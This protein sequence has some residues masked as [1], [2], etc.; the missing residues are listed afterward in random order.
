MKIHPND[1]IERNKKN[2]LRLNERNG[3]SLCENGQHNWEIL[4]KKLPVPQTTVVFVETEYISNKLINRL[5]LYSFCS[6]TSCI[7]FA[8]YVQTTQSC[9]P[10]LFAK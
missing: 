7:F 6:A 4:L 5:I 3:T 9:W 2:N 1:P 10:S 8:F